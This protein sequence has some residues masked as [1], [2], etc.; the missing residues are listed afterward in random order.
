[1]NRFRFVFFLISV[2][3]FFFIKT[4]PNRK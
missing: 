1:L 4:E 2:W 3:L